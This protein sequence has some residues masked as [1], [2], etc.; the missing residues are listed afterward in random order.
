MKINPFHFVGTLGTLLATTLSTAQTY[1]Q[2]SP[3]MTPQASYIEMTAAN[4]QTNSLAKFLTSAATLV[5]QTEPGTELWF[6]LQD[7][8]TLAIFDIFT[9]EKALKAHFSGKVAQALEDN[10]SNLVQGGWDQGV[11]DNVRNGSVLS[12]KAPI[13]LYSATT[14]TY[15][16]LTAAL[17]QGDALAELLTAAGP[18][19]AETEPKTLY[20][21]AMRLDKDKF[22][23]FDIFADNSGREAHFA[24]QVAN[25]LKAK[26][27]MLVEGGWN[28]GV[29]KNVRNYDIL[30]IN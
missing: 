29:V 13:D 25:L 1:A 14:A 21:V 7:G 11:V 15:I 5:K 22:A 26:S 10:A 3:T 28:E 18:I 27:T 19:V 4:Q 8:N 20:W 23:I 16:H 30:A 12:V 9:D 2:E 6:A 24:G 17:G